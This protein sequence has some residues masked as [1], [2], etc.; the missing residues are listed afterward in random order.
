MMPNVPACPIIAAFLSHY[1]QLQELAVTPDL[2]PGHDP[3]LGHA[4][5]HPGP[6]AG[7]LARGEHV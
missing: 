2:W 4:W 6:V 7:D 5:L 3:A 1:H